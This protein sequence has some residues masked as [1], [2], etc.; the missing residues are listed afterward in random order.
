MLHAI[1]S[2]VFLTFSVRSATNTNTKA[3]MNIPPPCLPIVWHFTGIAST[4]VSDWDVRRT[5]QNSY[6]YKHSRAYIAQDAHW[7]S[8]QIC[9][10]LIRLFNSYVRALCACQTYVWVSITMTNDTPNWIFK[11][12]RS[13]V[14]RLL[15]SRKFWVRENQ[16]K[17]FFFKLT[18][19]VCV[20]FFFRTTTMWLITI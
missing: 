6:L 17:V 2:I 10:T 16:F 13:K 5:W 4:P 18:H 15:A 19:F 11:V 7:V 3:S 9:F 8:L 12:Q 14:K 20:P 1:W